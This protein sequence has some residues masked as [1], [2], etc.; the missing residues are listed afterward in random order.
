MQNVI[1]L[2]SAILLCEI[3]GL[4]GAVFT[5]MSVSTWYPTLTKPFFNPPTW[6]FAPAWTSLFFLMGVALYLVWL[7]HNKINVKKAIIIFIVQFIFNILWSAVFFGLKSPLA[8]LIVIVMLWI[9]IIWTIIEFYK[10]SKFAGL[11]L[12]P[13][14]LW[15]SFATLLNASI[16]Y[17]N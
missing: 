14:I 17:L 10:V 3:V 13:Y 1:K 15:V 5:S 9:L 8:G 2:V 6:L 12:V 4:S 11:L 7:R 16:Y